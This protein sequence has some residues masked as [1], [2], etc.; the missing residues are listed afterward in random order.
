MNMSMT[1]AEK[2]NE[3]IKKSQV[4]D[5]NRA[6]EYSGSTSDLNILAELQDDQIKPAEGRENRY[7]SPDVRGKKI[8]EILK[9]D[10]PEEK[11]KFSISP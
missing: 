8:S 6:K 5:Q 10:T 11:N 4:N 3:D 9:A 1:Q 7:G 2:V